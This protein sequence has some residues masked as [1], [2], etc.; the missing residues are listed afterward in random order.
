VVTGTEDADTIAT[1]SG[2]DQIDGLGGADDIDAGPGNDTTEGGT[3]NDSVTGG[4]GNDQLSDADGDDTY[5]FAPGDGQDVI[6]DL[7]GTDAIVF[8]AGIAASDVFFT[9]PDANDLIIRF[10][11]QRGPDPSGQRAVRSVGADR[12]TSVRRRVQHQFRVTCCWR[13]RHRPMA[14]TP[15]S[16]SRRATCL[17]AD[18][19][20]TRSP[21]PTG[22]MTSREVPGRTSSRGPPATTR[23]SGGT[24]P[25]SLSG[26]ENDDTYVYN[27][28]DGQDTIDDSA[29]TDTIAFGPG[30]LAADITVRRSGSDLE[31]RFGATEDRLTIVNGFDGT[32]TIETLQFDDGTVWTAFDLIDRANTG[33]AGDDLLDGTS[34]ADASSAWAATTRSMALAG[35]DSLTGGAGDDLVSGGAEGDTYIFAAGDGVDI[36]DDQGGTGTD[37]LQIT[38][39]G[40]GDA[41]FSRTGPDG[42]DLTIRFAGSDDRIIVTGQF[43]AVEDGKIESFEIGG[44]ILPALEVETRV[45]P[46][47]G[48]DGDVILG[49][50]TAETLNGTPLG[51]YIEGGDGADTILGGDGDDIF[52]D[53]AADDAVDE[54]TGGAGRDTYRY[55]P[56]TPIAGGVA[57]D[58][59]TDFTPGDGGDIIRLAASV[60]NPFELGRLSLAQDGADTTVLLLQEDGST[61]SVLRL[62]GV[63]AT[64]LTAANFGGVTPEL[65]DGGGPDPVSD[66]ETG[67]LI[68]GGPEADFIFGNGGADTISGFRRVR[69]PCRRRRWRQHLRRLRQ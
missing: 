49:D 54:L 63:D 69:Q 48:A 23:L 43:A 47:V 19:G 5:F 31:L 21:G 12:G 58:V 16:A 24:G 35:E 2:D 18:R 39:H 38:G 40:L 1:G 26:G 46:D 32:G 60:P 28:G 53:I 8:A 41:R 25:D 62:L 11:R 64:A 4:P 14:R 56:V 9:Q 36:I 68:D 37:I 66:D 57:E 34:L 7:A 51:D 42:A 67:N 50:E 59:I 52:G 15:F 44:A 17:S 61:T 3:G 29:G 20:M 10:C 45:Q 30:L 33:T 55:L 65:G 13:H 6:S 22:T 27:L